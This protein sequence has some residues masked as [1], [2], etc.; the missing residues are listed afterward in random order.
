MV[1]PCPLCHAPY[2]FHEDEGACQ[3]RL[4]GTEYEHLLIPD[5]TP[6]PNLCHCGFMFGGPGAP[7]CR[8]PRHSGV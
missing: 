3:P 6:D 1:T 7:Q 4:T 8:H 2:G 5:T